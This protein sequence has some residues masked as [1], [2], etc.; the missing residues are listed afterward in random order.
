MSV[1]KWKDIKREK[2]EKMVGGCALCG[3]ETAYPGAR[4]CG[5]VCVFKWECGARPEK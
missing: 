2:K 4:F 3:C 1:H 5:A